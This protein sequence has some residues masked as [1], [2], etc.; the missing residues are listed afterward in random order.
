MRAKRA[1]LVVGVG[2]LL[3]A[4]PVLGHH[5]FKGQYDENQP[6]TLNGTVTKLIWKNPHVFLSI[7]VREGSGEVTKWELELDSPNGLMSEGW[8]LDSFK[9]GDQVIVTGYRAKNGSN[10]AR[11][12]KV[13][14]AAR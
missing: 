13:T 11:A 12:R 5:W 2:L 10:L 7:D 3:T 4:I 9:R 8:K 1:V 14:L 6:I